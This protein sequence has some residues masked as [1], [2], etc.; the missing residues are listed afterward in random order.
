MNKKISI[1]SP[2]YNEEDNIKLL[3]ESITNVMA[4]NLS[5][6]NYEIIFID[7]YSQ[8]NTRNIIREICSK[9]NK[10]KAIF[11]AKN[12]GH[13]RSPYYGM[14]QT[15]GDA[16]I[17]IA[18]DLQDPP[19]MI[20]DFVKKWENGNK[21]VVA[22]KNKSKE[23]FI[24]YRIRTMYYKF[25]KKIA[26]TEQIEHFTGFG[27]YDKKFIDVLRDLKDPYPYFRGLI[28][29]LGYP[30]AEVKYTQP[31]RERGITKNNFYTLY[32]IAMLGITSNSKV[33]I[34][35]ATMAG[36]LMSGISLLIAIVYLILKLV[37]WNAFPFGTAPIMIGIFFFSS[38]QLFFI[39]L[40]GEY[41]ININTKVLN[42]PLV[43]EEERINY[44]DI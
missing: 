9:D 37:Y 42:R 2:C 29:E 15:D 39:G 5:E 31:R 16:V 6:Y 24:M 10:V 23:N 26:D 34:R 20:A 40:I 35:L 28:S 44:N 32:D 12:F 38:I 8:D 21:I 30:F 7:N 4:S 27:L 36:F 41:V 13:I 18:S 14:M 25:I 11:N 17:L 19:A 1:V 22:I 33:P 43:V 3:Y